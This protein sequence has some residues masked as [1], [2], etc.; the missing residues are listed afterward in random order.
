MVGGISGLRSLAPLTRGLWT[1]SAD[2]LLLLVSST[3]V[4]SPSGIRFGLPSH[5]DGIIAKSGP[6]LSLVQGYVN[7]VSLWDLR[8]SEGAILPVLASAL[9]VFSEGLP[10]SLFGTLAL[11]AACGVL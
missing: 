7:L 4:Y 11:A 3:S 8:L 5:L 10:I 6:A 2:W 1:L 9:E